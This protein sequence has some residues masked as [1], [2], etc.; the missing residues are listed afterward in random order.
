[1]SNQDATLDIS[2][3][4]NEI[5]LTDI[6]LKKIP[7]E[8]FDT[9]AK[10]KIIALENKIESLNKKSKKYNRYHYIL[11]LPQLVVNAAMTSSVLIQH[12]SDTDY[13]TVLTSLGIFNA[14]LQ[15]ISTSLKYA[16]KSQKMLDKRKFCTKLKTELEMSMLMTSITEE[17]KQ[18]VI[19]KITQSGV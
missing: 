4:T 13:K 14:V 12:D 3:K 11:T 19:R 7:K 16:Q 1:M 15:S 8:D 18:D 17:Y 10:G 6:Q 2:V 9:Y 5:E